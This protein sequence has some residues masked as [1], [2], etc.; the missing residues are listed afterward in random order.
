[1][2]QIVKLCTRCGKRFANYF[3][4][5]SGERL[6][7]P[8]LLRSIERKVL[9]TIRNYSLIQPGDKIGIAISG[10]KDSITLLRILCTLRKRKELP[11]DIEFK[12]FTIDEELEYSKFKLTRVEFVKKLC[13]EFNIEYQIFKISDL[14]GVSTVEVAEKV[15]SKGYKINMCTI[16]GV[17]RRRAINIVAKILNI[18]KIATAH[19]LDDEAQ[20]VLL[21]VFTN[22]LKRF[23]WFGVSTGEEFEEIYIPRIKP[24]RYIREE[25]LALYAYYNNI[26]FLERECPYIKY[27][28]RYQL[29]F[30]LADLER[31]NP[32]I[33]Y[34]I[35]SFGD[36]L[37]KILKTCLKQIK[38]TQVRK[39]K[40]CGYPTSSEVCRVC[41]LLS[42]AGL[43]DNYLNWIKDK[44]KL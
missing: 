34:M 6:C 41:D 2:S 33:K 10:G 19:N 8:C 18:N 3:R 37:S 16:C 21:N 26:P 23:Y 4:L 13:N 17:L 31:R 36:E 22:D 12:A 14:L 5:S 43:L 40:Y 15:W 32:N 44:L 24:L 28:P 1:M 30:I 42:K 39:C 20:T 11:K 38:L 9:E 25:E 29:K 7:I 27:N 35:V